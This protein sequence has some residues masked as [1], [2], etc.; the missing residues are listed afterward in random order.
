ML[1]LAQKGLPHASRVF[2]VSQ[3]SVL[4][5]RWVGADG[6][7]HVSIQVSKDKQLWGDLVMLSGTQENKDG[8]CV[9]LATSPMYVRAY[10]DKSTQATKGKAFISLKVKKHG[11][12]ENRD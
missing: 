12:Q 6:L 7:V 3:P 11:N 8:I 1:D 10:V 2:R 4:C 5:V 9:P